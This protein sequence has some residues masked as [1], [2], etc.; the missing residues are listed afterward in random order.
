MI[1]AQGGVEQI[2]LMGDAP[3][4]YNPLTN[5]TGWALYLIGES[6]LTTDAWGDQSSN[7]RDL[8]FYNTPSITSENGKA[9]ITLNG[10][11]EFGKTSAFTLA[12]PFAIIMVFKEIS[13]TGLGYVDGESFQHLLV[14]TTDGANIALYAGI[15]D[16]YIATP[17]IPW[18]IEIAYFDGA[19]STNQFNNLTGS[20]NVGTNGLDG[21]TLGS[22]ANGTSASNIEVGFV[23]VIAN[24]TVE[25]LTRI[26]NYFKTYYGISYE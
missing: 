3:V 22:F 4:S 5:E 26:E 14:W 18:G 12:Q 20:G 15:T 13:K 2:I 16:S 1:L 21:F 7:N 17:T 10:S 24:P 11:N 6:E 25:I 23:G 19:N 9:T 8:A